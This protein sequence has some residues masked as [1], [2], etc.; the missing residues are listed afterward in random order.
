MRTGNM[1]AKVRK[2]DTGEHGNRGE[3]GTVNRSEADVAVADPAADAASDPMAGRASLEGTPY[4]EQPKAIAPVTTYRLGGG[5]R[6]DDSIR[7]DE[8]MVDVTGWLYENPDV[9]EQLATD[10]ELPLHGADEIELDDYEDETSGDGWIGD[11]DL[12]IPTGEGGTDFDLSR[13]YA[14]YVQECRHQGVVPFSDRAGHQQ[15]K[16]DRARARLR[17]SHRAAADAVGDFAEQSRNSHQ[18]PAQ[19]RARAAYMIYRDAAQDETQ[20]ALDGLRALGARHGAAYVSFPPDDDIDDSALLSGHPVFWDADGEAMD[21][22]EDPEIESGDEYAAWLFA[23]RDE[24]I[25]SDL[26][27]KAREDRELDAMS[28]RTDHAFTYRCTEKGA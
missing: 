2:R 19:A 18:T 15:R 17:E 6:G 23:D 26:A 20:E 28:D 13:A 25:V 4:E 10:Y 1:A 21:W 27:P 3:F 7:D 14:E 8:Q 12:D 9:V 11:E 22:N 5:S 24:A 16:R